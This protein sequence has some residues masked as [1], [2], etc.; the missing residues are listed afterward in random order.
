MNTS[1]KQV[2]LVY[3]EAVEPRFAIVSVTDA[4]AHQLAA[5]PAHRSASNPDELD[6]PLHRLREGWYL[7]VWRVIS[8]DGH[9]VRGAFTFA[10]GPNA[11]PAPQFAI[12]NLSET[13]ATPR[14]VAARWVALL[15]MLAAIGLF[16]FRAVIA[17]PCDRGGRR[18]KPAGGFDRV[19]GG[20]GARARRGPRLCAARDRTVRV[21]LV[22]VGRRARSAH[23]RLRVRARVS[24]PRARPRAVR[25][26][27]RSCAVARSAPQQ[28]QR[29]V[30]SLLAFW[31]AL[32]AGGAAFLCS[33]H[34]RP[35]VTDVPRARSLSPSTHCTSAPWRSGSVGS[36]VCSFSG[37][38]LHP[39][40]ESPVWSWSV[41]RFSNVAFVSVLTLLGSGVGASILHLPTLASLWQ[42]SYGK[43]IVLKSLLL[44]AAMLLASVNLLRTKPQLQASVERPG[45]GPAQATRFCGGSSGRGRARLRRSARGRIALEPAAAAEG[46]RRARQAERHTG[47][48]R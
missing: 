20:T 43:T 46:A 7:V 11:G 25:I 38:A 4:G 8:V 29:S 35:R 14:L 34:R 9:P 36:S 5:G 32:L 45:A 16:V 13:A 23:A 31:G 12:P 19:L 44:L 26:C 1:P 24:R 48:A 42:T 47:R 40:G 6:V 15:A 17:R 2:A 10:V 41:P 22:L 33:R 39:G 3:S 18:H 37:G 28:A 30:A 21:A 27:R